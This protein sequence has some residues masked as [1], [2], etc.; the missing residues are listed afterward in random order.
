MDLSGGVAS[1]GGPAHRGVDLAAFADAV[2]GDGDGDVTVTGAGTAAHVGGPLTRA[3]RPVAAPQ[4]I[5]WIE[6]AEMTVCCGA[7]TPVADLQGALAG[8]GQEV[9]LPDRGGTVGGA[10]MVGRS[11]VLRST[12]GAVR[13]TLLQARVVTAQGRLVKAGGPTVKNVSGYD[14]CRLLVGSLGT[15]AAVGEVI[16]RTR[17]LPAVRRWFQVAAGADPFAIRRALYRPAAVLWDG[18][19]VW[20]CLEGHAHDVDAAHRQVLGG[21]PEVAGPPPLPAA[22]RWSV[23]PGELAVLAAT[24]VPGTFVAEVGVGVVHHTVAAPVRPV[25]AGV[26]ALHERMKAAFDPAGRLNPGRSPL[27]QPGAT[28]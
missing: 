25:D 23:R 18:A 1:S 26:V 3:V 12:Q 10:L 4:G 5:A 6:P 2:G 24:W 8:H 17:P 20:V 13:E 7:G 16:L 11:G 15:L 19:A 27:H 14:L 28:A 22:G 9:A 21:A